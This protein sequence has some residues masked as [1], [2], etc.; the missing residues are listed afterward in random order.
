MDRFLKVTKAKLIV[1]CL[2]TLLPII[3]ITALPPILSEHFK[4]YADL[5]ALRYV[6]FVLVEGVIIK[7]ITNYILILKK[8]EYANKA[9]VKL[10]DERLVFVKMKSCALTIKIILYVLSIITVA[11]GFIDRNIFY[12]LLIVIFIIVITLVSTL[13]YYHRKY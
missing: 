9:Y 6:L 8:E 4:V 11:F 7:K 5:M 1:M 3:V 12:T 13:L 10:H 2:A